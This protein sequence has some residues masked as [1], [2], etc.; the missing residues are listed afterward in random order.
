MRLI[1]SSVQFGHDNVYE[2]FKFP[3]R[4]K[5]YPFHSKLHPWPLSMSNPTQLT[6]SYKLAPPLNRVPHPKLKL[7]T[8]L[9]AE[10]NRL[11]D[12]NSMTT[13][14]DNYKQ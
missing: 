5:L 11:S 2:L 10:P 6:T 3:I 9:G 4:I 14:G 1:Y 12:H 8:N 13:S 7:S